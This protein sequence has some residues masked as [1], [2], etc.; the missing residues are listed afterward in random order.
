MPVVEEAEARLW[1]DIDARAFDNLNE[2]RAPAC[3]VRF[4]RSCPT[5]PLRLSTNVSTGR[6]RPATTPPNAAAS[7][8]KTPAHRRYDSIRRRN[9]GGRLSAPVRRQAGAV[10]ADCHR[11]PGN[12]SILRANL[13]CGSM[14][15]WRLSI[16]DILQCQHATAGLPRSKAIFP[17]RTTAATRSRSSASRTARGSCTSRRICGSTLPGTSLVERLNR[18]APPVELKAVRAIAR[19]G[20]GWTEFIDHTGCADEEGCRRFFRRAGAWLALF[21]CFAATDM[22]QEN[23]I[24]AGDHPVPIDLEMILQ[25]TAEE[26]KVQ[27]PEGQAFNAAMDIVANSVMTVGLLPAYGRSPDNSLVAIGGMTPDSNSKIRP[28]VEPHKLRRRCGPSKSK[29]EPQEP[30]RT[31]RMSMAATPISA[32]TSRISS[33][34]S[35]ITR[36]FCCVRTRDAK[37]GRSVRRLCRRSRPQGHSRHPILLHAASTPEKSSDHGR[38]RDLVRASRLR[39]QAGGLGERSRSSLA[40]A[41]LPNA[42]LSWR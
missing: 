33:R 15:I 27:D 37:S 12:G 20:Y 35:R 21:H 6:E 29:D 38:R 28:Q 30:I 3:A 39:R 14:P 2:P 18:A 8:G 34:A 13:C 25:A 41:A 10:A 17:I 1:S 31:C 23:M 19:D 9:E 32:T 26:H 7:G 5:L 24:A 4:S 36:N 40:V 42:Q 11:S 22:H 16:S